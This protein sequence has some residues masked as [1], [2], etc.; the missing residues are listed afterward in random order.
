MKEKMI[1]GAKVAGA[2]A[3]VVVPLGIVA[4]GLYYALRQNGRTNERRNVRQE[5]VSFGQQEN[6]M[7]FAA[8]MGGC[9]EELEE[10][11]FDA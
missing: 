1:R 3:A 7:L 4:I 6:S 10:D 9:L 5:L 2:A 8:G 11:M